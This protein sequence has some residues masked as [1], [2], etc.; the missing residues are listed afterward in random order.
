MSNVQYIN[1]KADLLKKGQALTMNINAGKDLQEVLK[2]NTG[3]QG[4]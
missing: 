1:P 2:S 4:T 3:P